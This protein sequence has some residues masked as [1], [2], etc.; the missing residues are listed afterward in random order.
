MSEAIF[1]GHLVQD[2]KNLRSTKLP[3]TEE[4]NND[5]QAKQE[6]NNM[7]TNKIM[8]AMFPVSDIH[9]LS[10]SYSD[11]TGGIIACSAT[12][13]KYIFV[14]YHYDTNSIHAVPIKSRHADRI[15]QAWDKN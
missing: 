5:L 6:L 10:K 11:Q 3:S 1:K 15:I 4:N 8:C 12:E 9:R 7:K 2:H 13:N 14:L